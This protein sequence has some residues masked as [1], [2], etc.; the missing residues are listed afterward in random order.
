MTPRGE[1]GQSTVELAL[2]LPIFALLIMALIE[3]GL[4]LGDKTRLAHAAREAARVAAVE[5]EEHRVLEAAE[6]VG[7]RPLRLEVDPGPQFRV[8]G[9]AITT[10]VT[11]SPLSSLPLV[12]PLLRNV[13]MTESATMRIEKP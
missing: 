9:D 2:C 11:Y 6:A 13:T 10:T 3:I 4:L 5:A 8:Q 12:A 7:L 1:R